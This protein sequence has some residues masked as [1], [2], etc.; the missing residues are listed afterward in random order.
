M[1][2]FHN[3]FSESDIRAFA[4]SEKVGI[5][6]TVTPEGLPHLSLLTSVMASTPTQLTIGEFCKGMSKAYMQQ[7]G[8]IGFAIVT[9]DKK[10]WRGKA[11]WTHCKK[12][13]PEYEVYNQQPMFR[14]NTYFGINTVHYLDLKETTTGAP[15]PLLSII[16]SALLT[17]MAKSGAGKRNEKKAL[18]HF[19][20]TLFDRLDALK[21]LSFI[22][23]DGFPVIIPVIQCQACGES[24]LAFHPGAFPHELNGLQ[25]GKTMAV[26]GMTMQME[27]VLVRGTFNGYARYR[28]VKL[29]T[30][31]IDWV[32][33]SM[34]PTHGQIYPPQP[35]KAVVNF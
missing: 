30:L 31:D 4:P 16:P 17:K 7:T 18:T 34:P 2:A 25:P 29:G 10:L 8:K 15:L 32:Y 11:V 14:Y 35:Q 24:R 20:K 26:F 27:D 13:G 3:H 5:I 19:G 28:G 33:N 12:E 22:T 9:L 23:E 6:A 21:F 1:M